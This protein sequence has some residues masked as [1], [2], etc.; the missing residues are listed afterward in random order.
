MLGFKYFVSSNVFDFYYKFMRSSFIRI[1]FYRLG[2][3]NIDF[4]CL[5]LWSW[6]VGELDCEF[7]NV[8]VKFM[9]VI[10]VNVVFFLLEKEFGVK[11]IIVGLVRFF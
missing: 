5:R 3:W 9:F 6:W 10:F 4:F 8:V 7:G 2:N 11:S 1:F